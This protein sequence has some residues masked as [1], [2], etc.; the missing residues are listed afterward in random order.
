VERVPIWGIIGHEFRE[1]AREQIGKVTPLKCPNIESCPIH[2]DL[3]IVVRQ[4]DRDGQEASPKRHLND[5]DIFIVASD[6]RPTVD[7]VVDCFFD[8]GLARQRFY[9]LAQSRNNAIA[10]NTEMEVLF[11]EASERIE[12][13]LQTPSRKFWETHAVVRRAQISVAMVHASLVDLESQLLYYEK[14]RAETLN[15]LKKDKNARLFLEYFQSVTSPGIVVP[16]S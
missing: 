8:F 5:D 9:D 15:S 10:T 4:D 14:D 13:L 16:P 7:L 6:P 12:K 2:P 3:V 11:D 1:L